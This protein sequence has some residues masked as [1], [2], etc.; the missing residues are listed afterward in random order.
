MRALVIDDELVSRKKLQRILRHVGQS[1]A[2]DNGQAGL[3]LFRQAWDNDKP[4]D[5]I[6]LDLNMPGMS[7]WEVL[8]E[9]RRNEDE[10]ELG[11][12]ARTKVVMVTIQ[13]DP[14][15]VAESKAAG[16]DDY[17]IKPFNPQRILEKIEKLFV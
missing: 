5:L 6:C 7:G 10:M 17:I 14:Q 16:C 2:V 12:L 8:A 9:L 15:S 11:P 1:E 3:E 4:Y 13:S